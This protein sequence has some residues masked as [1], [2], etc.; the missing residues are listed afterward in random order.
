MPHR[1]TLSKPT[2]RGLKKREYFSKVEFSIVSAA[3]GL[4]SYCKERPVHLTTK[5]TIC[6]KAEVLTGITGE[7]GWGTC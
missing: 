2:N 4:G 1:K 6:G 5:D 7:G 3:H